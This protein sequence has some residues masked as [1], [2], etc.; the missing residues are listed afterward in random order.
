MKFIIYWTLYA[1]S[2]G[3]AEISGTISINDTTV[4]SY[5]LGYGYTTWNITE[6]K[7]IKG[8]VRLSYAHYYLERNNITSYLV[9]N[10]RYVYQYIATEPPIHIKLKRKDEY[11]R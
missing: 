11:R 6:K 4:T 7:E 10:Q 1:S 3:N 5:I 9:I 8:D 2:L